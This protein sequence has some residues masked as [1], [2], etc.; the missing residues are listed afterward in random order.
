MYLY[1]AS[2]HARVIIDILEASDEPIFGLYDDDASI[3]EL[4]G[5]PVLRPQEVLGPL[6][7]SIGNNEVRRKIVSRLDTLY[8]VAVDPSAIKSRSSSLGEGTV[9]MQ[10][11]LSNR[12]SRLAAIVLSIRERR[13]IMSVYSGISSISLRMPPFAGTYALERERKSEPV[14]LSFPELKL[15]SGH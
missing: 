7:V 10:G 15:V 2:G 9:V 3:S 13:S 1:G 11:R 8:G 4:K 12:M 5:Y 6:I 14:R